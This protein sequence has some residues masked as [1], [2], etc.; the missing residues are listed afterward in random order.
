ESGSASEL[1]GTISHRG[2]A[3]GVPECTHEAPGCRRREP[4]AKAASGSGIIDVMKLTEQELAERLAVADH[5]RAML[6]RCTLEWRVLGDRIL[7]E[8]QR[9]SERSDDGR[10]ARG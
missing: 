6:R 7:S 1:S 9:G 3:S 10:P 8:R 2:V 5:M 4:P